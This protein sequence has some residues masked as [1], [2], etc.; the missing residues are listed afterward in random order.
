[1][2]DITLRTAGIADVPAIAALHADS[3]RR[4]YRGAYTDA[5]LD[6]DVLADR[7]AVWS[8]RLA[9]AAGTAGTAGTATIIAEHDGDD[10]IA[11]FVHVVLDR[12]PVWGSLVDNLHVVHHRHRS[13]VGRRL[14]ARAARIA[15]TAA[16][17]NVLHLWVLEQNVAAQRFYLACGAENRERGTASPPRGDASRLNGTPGKFRMVWT[18]ATVLAHLDS[19]PPHPGAA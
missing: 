16:D 9:A 14:L 18:D 5:Y 10:G 2:P 3:W 7:Q 4:H 11:G 8:A 15:V 6:G 17:S 1:M 13:G 19:E 12:D